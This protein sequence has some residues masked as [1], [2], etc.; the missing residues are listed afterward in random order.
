MIGKTG[1][2]DHQR[3]REL[4]TIR[5]VNESE[6]WFTVKILTGNAVSRLRNNILATKNEHITVRKELVRFKE[7]TQQKE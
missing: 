7:I 3:W 4:V 6:E 2:L 5:I 1:I